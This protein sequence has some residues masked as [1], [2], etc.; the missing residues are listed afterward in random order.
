MA[1]RTVTVNYCDRCDSEDDIRKLKLVDPVTNRQASF[2]ACLECRSTIALVEWE[3]LL[4]KGP[5]QRTRVIASGA[6]SKTGKG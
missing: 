3:K 5:R 1:K 6:V 4:K 2:D